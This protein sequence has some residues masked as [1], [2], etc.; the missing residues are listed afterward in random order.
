M[1]RRR[2]RWGLPREA[3]G[4]EKALDPMYRVWEPSP[5]QIGHLLERQQYE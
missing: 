3:S 5:V 1:H 4:G 2:M